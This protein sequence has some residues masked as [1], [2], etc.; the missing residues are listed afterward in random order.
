VI[1]GDFRQTQDTIPEVFFDRLGQ[2]GIVNLMDHR[3]T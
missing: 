2:A 1:G 3:L